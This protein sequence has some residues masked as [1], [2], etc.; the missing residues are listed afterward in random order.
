MNDAVTMGVPERVSYMGEDRLHHLD[1]ERADFLN[2]R[3]EGPPL[4]VFHDEIQDALALLHGIDG[5]DVRMA[6]RGGG[7]RLAL[8]PLHHPLSHV[9]QGGRQH[10]DR[11]LAVEGE[12]VGQVDRGH[13]AAPQLCE[14][15]V[16]A[17]RGLPQG[18]QQRVPLVARSAGRGRHGSG[19]SHRDGDAGAAPRAERDPRPDT[20]T[21]P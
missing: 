6:E 10:L 21:A 13:P 5:D 20:G 4:H 7:A 16:F 11:H 12:V 18:V 14:N 17:Q 8:E 15:L 9:E 2:D 19:A 3:I 1:G